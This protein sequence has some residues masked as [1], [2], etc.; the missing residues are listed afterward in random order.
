MRDPVK[1]AK[2]KLREDGLYS[3]VRTTGDQ[4]TRIRP[5]FV[6][7]AAPRLTN[8][9]T[10]SRLE[11]VS[12]NSYSFGQC[13]SLT[14]PREYRSNKPLFEFD[15]LP[16]QIH[17]EQPCIFELNNVN[18]LPS[19][20]WVV[21]SDGLIL[22]SNLARL[23]LLQRELSRKPSL[24]PKIRQ[25]SKGHNSPTTLDLVC[26]LVDG[27]SF[28]KWVTKGLPR[29]EAIKYYEKR[30]GNLP[31]ILLPKDSPSYII[32]SMELFGFEE[33]QW[34]KWDGNSISINTLVLPSHRSPEHLVS[35][36]DHPIVYDLKY[37][38]VA[39][40]A[41]RWVRD[42]NKIKQVAKTINTPPRI[43]ISRSDANERRILNQSDLESRLKSYGFETLTLSNLSLET[44]M[45]TFSN[46]D[47][48][49]APHGAGLSNLIF[50]DNCRVIELFGKKV[51]PTYYLLSRS[52]D[53]NYIPHRGTPREKDIEVDV[54]SIEN[55]ITDLL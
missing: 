2:N 24:I 6:K 1:R 37:K 35:A 48:V 32:E 23:D 50:S 45:K 13:E 20:G 19:T 14:V 26:S 4:L 9:V 11:E 21:S 3:L 33:N 15:R 25:Y 29:L 36:Y 51:K 40:S 27:D 17:F 38:A 12:S 39:P 55:L 44:Q 46:A 30:T 54:S 47:I 34:S 49:V 53:L 5:L 31:H 41:C 22:E 10:R 7:Y 42:Q 43:L 28:S 16:Q 18:I 52:L 8:V